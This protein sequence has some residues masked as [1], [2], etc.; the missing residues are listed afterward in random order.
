MKILIAGASGFIGKHIV[1]ALS[2][3]HEVVALG[4]NINRL[5][6][7]FPDQKIIDWRMLEI[8]SPDSYQIIINLCG[9]NIGDKRWTDNRKAEIIQS[10]TDTTEKLCRW[11]LTAKHPSLLR[12]I[13]A[14]A[15]GIYGL[16]TKGN[17]E[18]TTIKINKHCFSQQVVFDWEEIV[19]KN[20]GKEINYSFARFGV[21]L[22]KQEGMLKKL[23]PSY[24]LGLASILGDGQQSISWVHIDDL[25]RAIV[26]II[27]NP[28][29]SGPINIVAPEVI[30]Q[31]KLA[32]TMA[33]AMGRP[34]F[35]TMPA[36][37]VKLLFG[38]MGTELLLVG[39]DA[40]PKKLIASGFSFQ[41]N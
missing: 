13:N 15:V 17:T 1:S 19:R 35:L 31:K 11:A 23:E 34:C 27:Q 30:T 37:C 28:A 2:Y 40:V 24:K 25:V 3:E 36:L 8:E 10:R 32:Q 21:V 12:F 22:K 39:Q 7:C 4:R 5:T 29:L 26:F 18:E 6:T 41:Y 20:L 16:N 38:Q 33:H 9:E 14:S